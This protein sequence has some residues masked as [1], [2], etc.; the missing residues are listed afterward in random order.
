M[1]LLIMQFAPVVLCFLPLWTKCL[2]Q[3]A[4]LEHKPPILFLHAESKKFKYYTRQFY[5]NRY[6]TRQLT[7]AMQ[8]SD[9]GSRKCETKVSQ[10]CPNTRQ[11]DKRR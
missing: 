10:K 5:K 6:K 4:V 1:K 3:L 8:E 2:P 7:H 11:T 9:S